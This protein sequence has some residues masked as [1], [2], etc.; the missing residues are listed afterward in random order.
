MLVYELEKAFNKTAEREVWIGIELEV[1]L[2]VKDEDYDYYHVNLNSD[3]TREIYDR[4]DERVY[5]DFYPYQ[6][7]LRTYPHPDPKEVTNELISLFRETNKIAREIGGK[8]APVSMIR[9]QM[10]NGMHIH[11]SH[12]PR[13]SN[14][15]MVKSIVASYPFIIDIARMTLSSPAKTERYGEVLSLR[16]LESPHIGLIP[17]KETFNS[18]EQMWVEDVYYD[19]SKRFYDIAL[20]V[21]KR[22]GRTRIKD[23]NTIE[24]RMFDCVGSE[25]VLKNVI[26]LT[27]NVYKFINPQWISEYRKNYD[28]RAKLEDVFYV[29]RHNLVTLSDYVNAFTGTDAR[30]LGKHFGMSNVY[31]EPWIYELYFN[32][33]TFCTEMKQSDINYLIM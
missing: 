1:Y 17:I 16:I 5:R 11:I 19:S 14:K 10:F 21:N 33:D 6:L 18:L 26:E 28:M 27:Y 13:I 15:D 31:E 4:L 23:I 3:I 2:L 25:S 7:E 30:E 24:V 8:L 32:Y 22:H 29:I 9:G 12:T 20:N